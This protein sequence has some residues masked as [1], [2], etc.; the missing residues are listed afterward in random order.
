MIGRTEDLTERPDLVDS[1]MDVLA[2]MLGALRL[3]GGVFVDAELRQPFNLLSEVDREDCARYFSEPRHVIAYHYVRQ[4]SMGCRIGNGPPVEVHA[5]QAVLFPRNHKHHVFAPVEP[6]PP[7]DPIADIVED[8][9][10]L[11][12]R[13]AGEGP[14]TAIY[15][16]YLGTDAVDTRLLESL[17]QMLTIDV[18]SAQ[19]AWVGRSFAFAAEDVGGRSPELVGKLA[20]ALFAEAVR[21]YVADIPEEERGWLAG[22]RDPAVG[23]ALALIHGRYAEPLTLAALAREAG[24]SKTVLAD[25]FRALIDE[26]PMQYCA[27]WR[28]KVAADM[29]R[30]DRPGAAEIAYAVGFSSEAA[31]NRAF[32]REFGAPPAKWRRELATA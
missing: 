20:E 17:P 30:E 11:R 1:A 10:M 14:E 28:M 31:F 25:R 16:G 6:A 23:K 19:D 4:G 18:R 8:E 26:S 32:K 27:R 22:L 15:C 7:L 21:R 3:S 13:N 24:V 2:E 12:I 9:G 29:L 5:G